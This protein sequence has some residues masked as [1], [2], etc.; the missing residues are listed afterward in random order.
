MRKSFCRW[1][2]DRKVDLYSASQDLRLVEVL[3]SRQCQDY[4]FLIF[5]D[6]VFVMS[7]LVLVDT[8]KVENLFCFNNFLFDR[9]FFYVKIQLHRTDLE[10]TKGLSF[11]FFQ[12]FWRNINHWAWVWLGHLEISSEKNFSKESIIN[13]LLTI[14]KKINRTEITKDYVF[15]SKDILN[16]SD[17]YS[18]MMK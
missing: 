15:V 11:P 13:Y 16:M 18:I 2:Q 14:E 10:N 8:V 7:F 3:F 4:N 17:K 12:I 1:L 5:Q 6:R 9:I